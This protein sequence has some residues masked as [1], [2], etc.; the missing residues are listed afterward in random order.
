MGRKK[1][2][3]ASFG[4]C[5]YI[6]SFCVLFFFSL[7]LSS[8]RLSNGVEGGLGVVLAVEEERV[9]AGAPRV[10]VADTPDGDTN[11]GLD[12]EAAL[13]DGGEVIGGGLLDVELGGRDLLDAGGGEGL[14]GLDV[15]AGLAGGEMALGTCRSA[16]SSVSGGREEGKKL[17]FTK[18]GEGRRKKKKNKN[19]PMPSMGT[20]AASHF[21]TWLIMPLVVLA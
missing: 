12:V 15:G 11:A 13:D 2:W 1:G 4:L 8:E 16:E 14:E 7:S 19:I 18:D 9:G 6:R 3:R 17:A 20:P 10:G 5:I 21:L